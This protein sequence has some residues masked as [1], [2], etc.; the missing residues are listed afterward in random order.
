LFLG[1]LTIWAVAQ[2]AVLTMPC[3]YALLPPLLLAVIPQ[4]VFISASCSN[5]SL[6]IAASALVIWWLVRL[7]AVA[8]RRPVQLGEWL[9]LG[10]LLGVSALSKLQAL[11]LYPLAAGVGI[12]IA[13]RRRDWR[14]PLV[15][16]LPVA[17]PAL[18]IA[19]WWYWRNF[20]LYGD[21]FGLEHLVSINGQRTE[22]LEWEE[23]WLEFRGLRY[24]FW[25]LFGWFN[26]LLPDWI[27]RVLDVVAA[28]ALL[29][30]ISAPW[31]NR[32]RKEAQQWRA[33]RTLLIVWACL[34]FALV[35][36][37][38]NRATG[39][40]GRL[41][42]PA[43]GAVVILLVIGL[44]LWLRDLPGVVRRTAWSALVLL[45]LGATL[46]AGAVLFP[47]SYGAPRPLSALPASAHALDIT[48][49]SPEGE[50]IKLLGVET[51]TGRYY[52]GDNVPVTLYLTAPL[53][54]HHD[55]EVFVQLLDETRAEVGNVTTHP[56]WGR[57]P[58]RLWEPGALYADT[59]TVQV[60][61]RIDSRSPLLAQVYTGFVDPQDPQMRPLAAQNGAGNEITPFVAETVLLPWSKPDVADADL[62]PMQVRFGE[63]IGLVGLHQPQQVAAGET[64]TV[65][66]LWEAMAAPGVDYTAFVHL[67][68]GNGNWV[69]GYDQAPGGTRF[70]TRV[71][72]AGDQVLSE[73]AVLTPEDLP[74]GE[75]ATWLGLYDTA[76]EGATRLP[77][78]EADGFTTAH[79][80]IELGKITL[81]PKTVATRP[82]PEE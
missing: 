61:Q 72:A 40:Q 54:L 51:P 27:Y 9:F 3:R 78:L 59:Y 11:G 29:G 13:Y 28:I 8:E 57:Y 77:L 79:E 42:F 32:H 65:T 6:V 35:I 68:D 17:L 39:S 63:S 74:P 70:P 50:Q 7:L 37:W 22:P 36:Y 49:T 26:I 43:I 45:M 34:S 31:L 73:M 52:A 62:T 15:A 20:T 41:F 71:W 66:L 16:A 55:Y 38:V 4:F 21:W 76:S 58:T 12:A 23:W 33:G 1:A 18:L 30:L 53:P 56:G 46:Y 81:I 82:E 67:L 69:A 44:E 24:S 80:M 75:Y 47:R 25:G 48:F 60:Q 19:G 64:L 14:V 2:T 10:I 5:D